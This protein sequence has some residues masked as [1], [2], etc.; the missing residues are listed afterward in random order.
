MSDILIRDLCRWDRRLQLVVP[1]DQPV[2]P[3]LDR[4]ISWAVAVR[5]VPPHLP[6]L[7]GDELVILSQRVLT[8]IESAGATSRDAL[9]RALERA[10]IAALVTEAGLREQLVVTF[11]L[12]LFPGPLPFDFDAT[13]NRL[14]TEQRSALFR[15]S[16]QLSRD[17]S[18]VAVSG[19]IAAVLR[20]ASSASGRSLLLQDAEGQVVAQSGGLL[21]PLPAHQLLR[22]HP[23]PA[24][25]R[26]G[27]SEGEAVATT[28][29]PDR[30]PL[31]LI[32]A[33]PEATTEQDRL[34]LSLTAGVCTSLLARVAT[35]DARAVPGL[36]ELLEGKVH[37]EQA[38]AA[39]AQRLRLDVDR[40][41]IVGLAAG[42]AGLHDV[43]H[44][45][46]RQVG[47]DRLVRFEQSVAFVSEAGVVDD[48]ASALRRVPHRDGARWAVALSEP[49][50]SLRDVAA[51][52]RQAQY[53][54][55]LWH[56]GAL[57]GGVLRFHVVEETGLYSLLYA[58][59]GHPAAERFRQAVLGRLAV[60]GN[61]NAELLETLEAY[62][63]YGSAGEVAAR[64]GVHRNTVGYRLHRI[65]ELTGR[66]VDQPH[67]RL[68]LH[69]AVLLGHLPPP[70]R[71]VEI[72]GRSPVGEG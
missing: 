56:S 41:I 50:A 55:A 3:V 19:D 7:R 13:L 30:R 32:L 23:Y 33:S 25:T 5:A 37:G 59:W 43:E 42:T 27:L 64:L 18:R 10:P 66:S 49:V 24:V 72:Q 57:P 65:T 45:L 35:R 39:V 36:R 8:E 20:A 48:L 34:T 21:E 52:L 14:L 15:L 26:L 71:R 9:V 29:L 31:Y 60:R 17:L 62:L 54:L 69:V 47:E 58:L 1:R 2:D 28:I 53:L 44:V 67:D 38:L 51:G 16:S 40:S 70:N 63:T 6:P 68:L 11:P 22:I 61:R 46:L 12:L 4:P